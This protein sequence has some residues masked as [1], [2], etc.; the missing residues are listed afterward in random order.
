MSGFVLN[1]DQKLINQLTQADAL[2][3]QLGVTSERTRDQF[4]KAFS[5]MATIGVDGLIK[6]LTEA[7]TKIAELGGS[8][9]T[10]NGLGTISTQ[11]T[12]STDAINT[13]IQTLTQLSSTLATSQQQQPLLKITEQDLGAGRMKAIKKAQMDK[14]VAQQQAASQMQIQIIKGEVATQIETLKS[15]YAVQI[16]EAKNAG[17]AK[18]RAAKEEAAKIA[19]STQKQTNQVRV[20]ARLEIAAY[21]DSQQALTNYHK[22]MAMSEQGVTSRQTKLARLSSVLKDLQREENKYGN[23]IKRVK[24]KMA[25]L[26]EEQ[27]L[28]KKVGNSLADMLKKIFAFNTIKNFVTKLMTVRGEYEQQHRA[29][30]VL[31]QD[32]N[33]ANIIWNKTVQLAVRSPYTIKQLT[34]YSKQLAAYRIES[35]KLYDT[36]KRLADVSVGLGVDMQRVILAYGQVRAANFLRGT[37][38]RQ[39]TEAGIPML[40]ELAKYFSAVEHTTVTAAQVFDRISKRQV[41]FTDVDAVI[42]KMTDAGGIFYNMQEEMANTLAGMRSNLKDKVYLMFNE[43]G[44]Q[45]QGLLSSMLKFFGWLS[46]NWR[47]LATVLEMLLLPAVTKLIFGFIRA[48]K[49]MKL[50]RVTSLRASG[51]LVKLAST[52]KG[53]ASLMLTTPIGLMITLVLTLGAAM[54]ELNNRTKAMNAELDK[55]RANTQKQITNLEEQKQKVEENNRIIKDSENATNLTEEAETKLAEARAENT[56]ILDELK[57]RHPDFYKNIIQQKNGTVELTGAIEEQNKQLAK[58]AVFANLVKGS[59]FSQSLIKNS[60]LFTKRV[61]E[62]QRNLDD[63]IAEYEAE[64]ASIQEDYALGKVSYE[65]SKQE[66]ERINTEI[67]NLKAVK[68]RLNNLNAETMTSLEALSRPSIGGRR[69]YSEQQYYAILDAAQTAYANLEDVKKIMAQDLREMSAGGVSQEDMA[70]Y[71]HDSLSPLIADTGLLSLIESE[72]NNYFLE[73]KAIDVP[74]NFN[75]NISPE[76]I[77]KWQK[78][79]NKAITEAISEINKDLEDSDKV[80]FTEITVGT[81]VANSRD[82][83]IKDA[84]EAYSQQTDLLKRVRKKAQENNGSLIGTAYEGYSIKN[85]EAQIELQKKILDFFEAPYTKGKKKNENEEQFKRQLELIKKLR[86][87]YLKL[88]KEMGKKDALKLIKEHY[89]DAFDQIFQG[90]GVDWD[91]IFNAS[92]RGYVTALGELRPLAEK[93]GKA[94]QDAFEKELS[95]ATINVETKTK[96]DANKQLKQQVDSL[97]AQFDLSRE[98][99][100]LGLSKELMKS[101]FNVEYLDLDSLKSQVIEK[102]A[103]TSEELQTELKKDVSA[104]DWAKIEELIGKERAEEAKQSI[105]KINKLSKKEQEQQAKDFVKFLTKKLNETTVL[106]Q[107]S[108]GYI[109]Y[110]QKLFNEGKIDAEQYSEVVNKVIRETNEGISK[111][112]LNSFKDSDTYIK[113][114]GSLAGYTADELEKLRKS[115]QEVIAN[116]SKAFSADEINAYYDAIARIAEQEQKLRKPWEKTGFGEIKYLNEQYKKRKNLIKKSAELEQEQTNLI[117]EQKKLK[118]KLATAKARGEDTSQLTKDLKTNAESLA[119]VNSEI[120]KYAAALAMVNGNIDKISSGLGEVWDK[121]AIGVAQVNNIA[122]G[123]KDSFNEIKEVA[124]SFGV[125]TENESWTKAGIV[126]ESFAN[127]TENA[128]GMLTSLVNG[129]IGGFLKGLVGFVGSIIKGFNQFHDAKYDAIIKTEQK[130]VEKLAKAYD[131]LEKKI[132]DAMDVTQLQES[133]NAARENLEKQIEATQNMINA[134]EDKKATDNEAVEEY[135]SNLDELNEKLKELEAERVKTLGGFGDIDAM[136][137]ATEEFVDAWMEAYKE[138][139]DGLDALEGKFN[140]FLENTIKKQIVMRGANNILKGLYEN[141]D[142]MFSED[143]AGGAILTPEE[144]DAMRKLWTQYKQQLND[145]LLNISKSLGVTTGEAD[146]ELSGLQAGIQGITESQAEILT[147]YANSCRFFLS[148]INTTLSDFATKI[149]DTEG[150]SNPILSQLRIVAQQTTAINSLLSSLTKGGHTEGGLGLKVFIN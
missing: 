118:D 117:K 135:K 141:Y 139:G 85:I 14:M 121:A 37:E 12:Q 54:Y 30:Q 123:I 5:D 119:F 46:E 60:E 4:N 52:W 130:N 134:E 143:S 74:L 78:N 132:K 58:Q 104:I 97:F 76:E 26:R 10:G 48:I 84:Q 55:M 15:G 91:F 129:D 50:M 113:A 2:V 128:S 109:T 27:G 3:K 21:K 61:A 77:D 138:T 23:E 6:R 124:A 96:S 100:K 80:Y 31:L 107:K 35:D 11:A 102:F 28:I 17:A 147:T 59:W 110:A 70:K 133:S 7:Q 122:Q 90:T 65:Y 36:T 101:L 57:K 87:E 150:D 22:A 13:L 114:M 89:K 99:E 19:A 43:I 95:G 131:K 56:R 20:N 39:F 32:Y 142:A 67:R 112:R 40:D 106:I 145:Y 120:K 115:L 64:R 29:M 24:A 42:Q 25:E 51:G 86:S 69:S 53:L 82:K 72:L 41:L 136:K 94:A 146:G 148:S 44:A 79:Y 49:K 81:S 18:V 47:V 116:S 103:G 105:E 137:S 63:S 68:E 34:S 83:L 38:L 1:I 125:D 45:T 71:I 66:E 126:I 8:M 33:K 73:V 16:Q 149:F 127:A 88:N 108:G 9:S 75:F 98:L 93:A 144:A 111:V 92:E 140:E 62:V